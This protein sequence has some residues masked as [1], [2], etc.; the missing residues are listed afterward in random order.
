VGIFPPL[1]FLF[2]PFLFDWSPLTPAPT[3][4]DEEPSLHRQA[5]VKRKQRLTSKWAGGPGG[6][7]D[8]PL[9]EA[10]LRDA[11]HRAG[12]GMLP[13]EHWPHP[14]ESHADFPDFHAGGSRHRQSCQRSLC[15]FVCGGRDIPGF[16]I[17]LLVL[18][19]HYPTQFHQF[20]IHFVSKETGSTP[21]FFI[22]WTM[23]QANLG[24]GK[25]VCIRINLEYAPYIH[26]PLM[27]QTKAWDA[28]TILRRKHFF[29][30]LY[31]S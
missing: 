13:E 29:F 24:E 9:A 2:H 11:T 12:A 7:G 21:S 10:S 6:Q 26:F 15:V 25:H 1:W 31:S 20:F 8:T 23:V 16:L 22:V 18:F 4:E 5:C 3:V 14:S 28:L 17:S 19:A 27:L 30:D